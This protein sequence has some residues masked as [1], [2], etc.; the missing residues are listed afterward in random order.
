VT[1]LL[2]KHNTQ[3]GQKSDD[4]SRTSFRNIVSFFSW[5]LL[6]CVP[7]CVCVCFVLVFW[8]LC[9][10]CF[11]SSCVTNCHLFLLAS[12]VLGVCVRA[13]APRFVYNFLCFLGFFFF[14]L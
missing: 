9:M 13:C 8:P 4:G 2:T 10:L 12:S 11:V 14:V 7:L 5:M 3:R 6:V 1:Q